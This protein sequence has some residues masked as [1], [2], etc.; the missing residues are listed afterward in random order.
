MKVFTCKSER[1]NIALSVGSSSMKI[2]DKGGGIILK[3]ILKE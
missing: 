2:E 1:R 3:W